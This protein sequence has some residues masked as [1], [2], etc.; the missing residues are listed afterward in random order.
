MHPK[1]KKLIAMRAWYRRLRDY[2]AWVWKGR[3]TYVGC[4]EITSRR[5]VLIVKHRD[6]P[7]SVRPVSV[8]FDGRDIMCS[9]LPF[10]GEQGW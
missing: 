3:P 10:R 7:R 2:V 6:Y 4:L 9:L 8:Y 1:I 5:D